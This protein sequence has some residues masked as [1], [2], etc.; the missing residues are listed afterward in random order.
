MLLKPMRS[1]VRTGDIDGFGFVV[2]AGCDSE[3]DTIAFNESAES[4]GSDGRLMNEDI[5]G[6]VIGFDESEAFAVVEPLNDTGESLFR[7]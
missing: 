6:I 5:F 2:I 4:I 1:A 7:H 3:F